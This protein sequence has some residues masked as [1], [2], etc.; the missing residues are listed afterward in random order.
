MIDGNPRA[1]PYIPN[2]SPDTRAKMLQAVGVSDAEELYDGIPEHLKLGRLLDL[3][4]GL[5]SERDLRRHMTGLLN[6]NTPAADVISFLGG[7]CWQ[8]DVPAVC[9]EINARAEFLT[10]YGGDTYADLGKYQAIF[11][12]QSLIGELVGFEMV[13]AP[14]YDWAGAT[15]S[16]LMMAGRITGRPNVLVP[17]ATSPERLAHLR[18]GAKPQ[19][20]II[21]IDT[22]PVS[23]LMDLTHLEANLDANTAAVYL[24]VPGYLGVLDPRGEDIAGLGKRAGALFVVGVD[25]SSLGVLRPPA[26]YGADLVTGEAQPFGVHMHYSGGLC[27]FIASRD[28]PHILAEYPYLMVSAAPGRTPGELGFGWSTMDRT[29]YDKREHARDYAGTTQW[30]WGITAAVYLSLLGPQGLRELGEGIV[31]RSH[32]AMSQLSTIPGVVAPKFSASHFKE[33]VVDF[34]GT[35]KS[36]QDI[37]A[38]L[39]ERDIF[40]GHDLGPERPELANCALYCVTEVHSKSDIDRLVVALQE[41]LA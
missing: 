7:G 1:H 4:P 40:G 26:E 5:P 37:N 6:R 11:E 13:S 33:F 22:D 29:S 12:F 3:P 27:G 21:E 32:Y 24:E 9:D 18:N 25:G 15:T 35:G 14:V 19:L 30:L 8:H 20:T 36:V 10:A 34:S 31:Q 28:E 39:R 2:S 16:A 23:G 41:V 38:A 17:R